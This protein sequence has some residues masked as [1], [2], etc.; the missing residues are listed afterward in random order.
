MSK[1]IEDLRRRRAEL[2]DE[3][4][5][6][7]DFRRGSVT[8]VVRRCGKPGCRCSE[9]GD[10]G[11]GPNFRLTYKVNGRTS[12][13]SLPNR[14]IIKKARNEIAQYRRYQALSREFVEV[15]SKICRL[16]DVAAGRQAEGA[17]SD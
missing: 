12:S 2:L 5:A 4:A 17:P 6:L 1:Q 8:A 13:D 11:H 14:A 9:P 3:F 15:N 7:G 10:P 16:T